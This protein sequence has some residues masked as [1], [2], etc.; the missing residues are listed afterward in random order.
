MW[1]TFPTHTGWVRRAGVQ[2]S[3]QLRRLIVHNCCSAPRSRNST[4]GRSQH[5][6]AVAIFDVLL[7]TILPTHTA[8]KVSLRFHQVPVGITCADELTKLPRCWFFPFVLLRWMESQNWVLAGNDY[9][10]CKIHDT[11]VR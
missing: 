11:K 7:R 3:S 1:R 2:N 9:C 5:F 10:N 8:V 6:V 4:C